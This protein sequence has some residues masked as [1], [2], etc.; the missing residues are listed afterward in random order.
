MRYININV[1]MI[2][3]AYFLLLI[4]FLDPIT[5]LAFLFVAL[6]GVFIKLLFFKYYYY[7]EEY[8]LFIIRKPMEIIICLVSLLI[9]FN[10]FNYLINSYGFFYIS[11]YFLIFLI[12]HIIGLRKK[13]I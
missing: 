13:I 5:V 4:G 6:L 3:L 11:I 1:N 7:F 12:G 2:Y 8:E 9:L 10:D